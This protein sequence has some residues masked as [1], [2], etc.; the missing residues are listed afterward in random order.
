[1][2][3]RVKNDAY[4][5]P[6]DVA[7][8]MISV[9]EIEPNSK[10]LEPHVG[11]GRLAKAIKNQQPNCELTCLDIEN[12]SEFIEE[13]DGASFE[14]IDFLEWNPNQ[15][16]DYC[17]MNPPYH[18]ALEHIDKAL[19]VTSGKVVAL[20]RLGILESLKRSQWWQVGNGQKLQALYPLS[21]RPAYYIRNPKTGLVE[22]IG[23]CDSSGYAFLV[24]SHCAAQ[25]EIR[26]I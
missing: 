7:E 16:F 19:S 5:T 10:I 1:M 22:K 20:L 26:V 25:Q 13:I 18:N 21:K 14:Q 6:E 2:R 8:K 15:K 4:Y 17:F 12:N 9:I 23:G 24:F 11:I 3:E